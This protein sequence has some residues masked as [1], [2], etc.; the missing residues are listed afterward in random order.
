MRLNMSFNTVVGKREAPVVHSVVKSRLMIALKIH[1]PSA[2]AFCFHYS[3]ANAS[4]KTNSINM[5]L[6]KDDSVLWLCF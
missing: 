6:Q 5:C 2:M 1:F 4:V 3:D